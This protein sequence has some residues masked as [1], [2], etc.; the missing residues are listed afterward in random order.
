MNQKRQLIFLVILLAVLALAVFSSWD[1]GS[2][3][4]AVFS[5][6]KYQPLKVDDPQLR[7]DLL[8]KIRKQE[9]AGAQINIFTGRPIPPPV[10]PQKAVEP[11]K[12]AEPAGPP[13]LQVP[14]KFFGFTTDPQS[15]KK[16]AFF[17]DGD[18]VFIMAEGE[19]LQNKFRLLRIGA[20]SAEMEEISSGR[21]AT[22]QLEQLPEGS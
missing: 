8:E 4:V 9:Y 20:T 1:E 12:P 10:Q 19:L 21:R 2:P 18:D 13:P 7:M 22:L 3:M 11:P 5:P 14:V 6:Q 17:T 16:R 15:G